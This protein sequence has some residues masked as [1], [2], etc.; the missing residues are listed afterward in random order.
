MAVSAR[1][2]VRAAQFGVAAFLASIELT[3][4]AGVHP[5]RSGP[6]RYP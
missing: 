4:C 5:H 3:A 2:V 1:W 6:H